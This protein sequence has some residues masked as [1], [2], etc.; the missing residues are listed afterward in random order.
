MASPPVPSRTDLTFFLIP[1]FTLENA[2]LSLSSKKLLNYTLGGKLIYKMKFKEVK[3]VVQHNG[4]E[5]GIIIK[6]VRLYLQFRCGW[7]SARSLPGEAPNSR[8]PMFCRR[9]PAATSLF[10]W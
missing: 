3:K 8:Q 10:T 4:E 9:G 7:V 2:L 1:V 5:P 6:S